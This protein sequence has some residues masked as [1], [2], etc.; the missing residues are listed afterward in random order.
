MKEKLLKISLFYYLYKLLKIFRN[1]KP[2]THFGEFGEDIF[3]ERILRNFGRGFY[4]DV[5]CYH[6][7]KGSLTY[8]LYN[9]NWSGLNIDL[10][11]TS[12][13]LFNIA[14]SRDINLNL[15]ITNYDGETFYYQNSPINQQN[16]L[17]K[18]NE[19]QKKTKIKCFSLNTILKENKIDKFQFLN[20]DVEGS[21]LNVIKGVDLTKYRPILISIENNDLLPKDYFESE[22]YKILIE[23]NYVFINKIGVTNFFIAD[24]LANEFMNLIEI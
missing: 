24:N 16:S 17:I 22:I 12:I 20:I 8:K 11:K 5:G 4:V 10:S 2:S 18:T 19:Y 21:E 3:I 7:F 15:A 13:D 23:N 6:P 14:R 9:K 1:K